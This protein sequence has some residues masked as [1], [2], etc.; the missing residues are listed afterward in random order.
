MSKYITRIGVLKVEVSN[1][2]CR[3]HVKWQMVMLSAEQVDC[4]YPSTWSCEWRKH[5]HLAYFSSWPTWAADHC[6]R[7]MSW[8]VPQEEHERVSETGVFL[9][10]DSVSGTLCLLHYVTETS[11][12]YSLRDFWRHFCL[13]RAANHNDCC[14]FL[15]RVQIFLLTYLL[16]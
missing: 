1:N 10:L 5:V 13:S 2:I 8:R 7:L 6:D 15:R 12:L 16:T 14:F 9:S 4:H 3:R 11:H